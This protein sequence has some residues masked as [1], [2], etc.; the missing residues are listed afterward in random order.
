MLLVLT[1]FRGNRNRTHQ[2]FAKR[3]FSIIKI[4]TEARSFLLFDFCFQFV[5]QRPV[6]KNLRPLAP[7]AP[8]LFDIEIR[9]NYFGVKLRTVL[10]K[11]M[12]LF[13]KGEN[14]KN[15]IA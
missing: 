15:D 10:Q 4:L 2:T 6:Y 9:I 3:T 13:H 14:L 12:I 8:I 7:S 11:I 1:Y 5:I